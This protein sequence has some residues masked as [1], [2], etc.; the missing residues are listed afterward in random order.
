MLQVISVSYTATAEVPFFLIT[1][2]LS[3]VAAVMPVT[4]W[5]RETDLIQFDGGLLIPG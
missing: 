3:A 2:T 4:C 1:S 5:A